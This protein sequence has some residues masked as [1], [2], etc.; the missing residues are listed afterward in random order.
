MNNLSRKFENL[1]ASKKFL[2]ML[3]RGAH[4]GNIVEN[5]ADAVNI[6]RKQ[7]SDIVEI[8]ISMS[9][10]GDFFVFHDGGEPRLLNDNRNINTMSTKEIR[11]KYYYNELGQVL[12]KKVQKFEE[13]LSGVSKDV[14]F[15]IDRSWDH[16]STFL[17]YLDQFK[18]RYEYFILKSPVEKELLEL[19]DNHQVNYM[20]FPIINNE[21]ELDLLEQYKNINVIG[22]EVI[23]RDDMFTFINSNRFDKYK[24]NG[25]LFIVNAINLDDDTKL[26]GSLSDE[27]SIT[28]NPDLGW[29]KILEMGV[30]GIQTDWIDLLYNYRENKFTKN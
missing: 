17:P 16:W 11:S 5:T 19:L 4:G 10:D 21:E 20:Y 9:T 30:N 27:V 2:I 8:D 14:F 7:G 26:F 25:Y 3:H 28:V 24:S 29:G 6:A 13:L 1:L 22:F 23:E 15:N 18:E 12:H